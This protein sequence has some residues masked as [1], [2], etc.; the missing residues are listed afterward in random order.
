[1][2]A[3]FDTERYKRYFETV[4]G[5]GDQLPVVTIPI[6]QQHWAVETRY[7]EQV[8]ALLNEAGCVGGV[9]D[10][11]VVG[12]DVQLI[13]FTDAA[14]T[15]LN[16]R[17][18]E[19]VPLARLSPPSAR[20]RATA[21]GA[22]AVQIDSLDMEWDSADEHGPMVEFII[23]VQRKHLLDLERV[24]QV[25]VARTRVLQAQLLLKEQ[26]GGAVHMPLPPPDRTLSSLLQ[27]I[28]TDVILV[29]CVFFDRNLH[30]KVPLVST[31]ARL[32][33]ARV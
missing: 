24:G 3:T 15:H 21:D 8:P 19:V 6:P 28:A 11:F 29:R 18:G 16:G 7:L 20:L 2:S 25:S 22:V 9:N 30:S 1:M 4:L 13:G 5:A 27:T 10:P 12:A 17:Y 33:R 32:K 31:L 14:N 23:P 26:Y